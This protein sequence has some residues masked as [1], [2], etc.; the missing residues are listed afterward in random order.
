MQAVEQVKQKPS[1][2]TQGIPSLQ[3]QQVISHP[4]GSRAPSLLMG[5]ER[6]M[7][8]LWASSLPPSS[9]AWHHMVWDVPWAGWGQLLLLCVPWLP[10]HPQPSLVGWVRSRRGFVPVWA[11]PSNN[12][13]TPELSTPFPAQ[14]QNTAP[15]WLL[16]RKLALAQLSMC[17]SALPNVEGMIYAGEVETW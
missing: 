7:P 10:V 17:L 12:T 16:W 8:L 6:Q 5:L 4:Q 15:S 13:N 2:A 1:K 9:P 3:G 14:T 11:L